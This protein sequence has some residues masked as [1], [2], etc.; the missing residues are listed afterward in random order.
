MLHPLFEKIWTEGEITNDWKC[1]LFVKLTKKGDITN[2]DNWRGIT[3]LSV[4][5]NKSKERVNLRLRKEQAG[6]R[7]NRSCIDQINTLRIIIEQCIECSSPLY[8]VFTDFEKAFDL[9]IREAVWKE[10]KR[11]VVPT[12]IVNLVKET[13]RGYACRVVHEGRVSEPISVQTGVR[14]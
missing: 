1:G 13:Y 11:H 4:L 12:Q 6:F 5:F 8:T 3:L 9:I 7:P 2:C 14:Q 10:V